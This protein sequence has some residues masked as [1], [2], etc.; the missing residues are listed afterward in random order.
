MH[1]LTV[2]REICRIAAVYAG[3]V[4]LGDV[5]EVGVELGETAGLELHS[6]EFCLSALLSAPPFGRARP[7]IELCPGDSLRVTFLEV[8]DGDS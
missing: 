4:R 5:L 2:A 1:E 7:R 8:D 3:P 6:L